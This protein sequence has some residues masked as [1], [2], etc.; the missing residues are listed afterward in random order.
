MKDIQ[1]GRQNYGR[2]EKFLSSG[3]E[4]RLIREWQELRS[5]RARESLITSYMPQIKSL[6]R[7]YSRTTN[8]LNDLIQEGACGFTIAIDKYEE[9]FGVRLGS[10]AK[11][12]AMRC[13]R[14]YRLENSPSGRLPNSRRTKD[15]ENRVIGVINELESEFWVKLSR[16]EE[17]LIC[18]D[19]RFDIS[20]LD[21]YRTFTAPPKKLHSSSD[22]ES[23]FEPVADEF[24]VIGTMD[25][26]KI[27]DLLEEVLQRLT[28]RS[29]RIIEARY[30]SDDFTSL[31]SL[32]DELGISRERIRQVEGGAMLDMRIALK[33]HGL[34]LGDLM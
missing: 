5:E 19:E 21:K 28:P 34:E 16:E 31:D 26:P 30:L 27:Q 24:D 23:G 3:E 14:E 6:A 13:M 7:R 33:E 1:T 9:R 2:V 15:M 25:A 32:S 10:F 12:D 22:E 4:L 18:N 8:D 17:E 11:Y 20:E 29:R